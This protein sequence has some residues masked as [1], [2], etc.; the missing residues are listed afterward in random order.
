M[1]SKSRQGRVKGKIRERQNRNFSLSPEHHLIVSEGIKT[2]PNYFKALAK[3][4]NDNRSFPAR[5]KVD[6]I[7]FHIEGVGKN[8]RDVFDDAVEMAQEIEKRES[9]RI[10]KVWVVYDKDDFPHDRFNVVEELCKKQSSDETQYFALWSNQCIE[11][12][13]LLH[14]EYCNTAL[15]RSDYERKLDNY[16]KSC[17]YSEKYEKNSEKMFEWLLPY[18]DEA[19][20]NSKRLFATYSEEA[21]SAK[22]DPATVVFQ[23]FDI[24]LPYI[25]R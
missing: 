14:F 2:E 17:G 16:L 15:H 4:I 24:L 6:F 1:A 20:R 5:E 9:V 25:K 7:R 8:T 3:N 18:I 13:F 23:L 19:M 12:W 11:L 21:T 10:R 22:K